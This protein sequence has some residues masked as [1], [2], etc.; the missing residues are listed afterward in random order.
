M[1][2]MDAETATLRGKM[3]RQRVSERWLDAIVVVAFHVEHGQVIE[4]VYAVEDSKL[5]ERAKRKICS[6]SLPDSNSGQNGDVQYFFRYRE[7][8][9]P[10]RAKNSLEEDFVYCSAFFRQIKDKTLKR[11]YFQKSVVLVS[12]NPFTSF[13]ED[14]TFVVG[15][16]FF[17]FG[18][19]VLE[20]ILR[21]VL[22][23]PRP[24]PGRT[25]KLPIAGSSI[26]TVVPRQFPN[27]R[28]LPA[29]TV[30]SSSAVPPSIEV[31]LET[32]VSRSSLRM[33]SA[34][35]EARCA[36][37][38]SAPGR[39]TSGP[40]AGDDIPSGSALGRGRA[41]D[42]A[43][44]G[45]GY[46]DAARSH[47]FATGADAGAGTGASASANANANA[48]VSARG[49]GSAPPPFPYNGASTSTAGVATAGPSGAGVNYSVARIFRHPPETNPG[50]FQDIPLF[51]TFGGLSVALWHI[52]ELALAGEPILV[53]APTPDRCSQAVLAIASLIAPI[54]YNGDYRPYFTI[55]DSDFMQI[56]RKHDETRGQDMPPTVL[57]VTNP[58]FLKTLEYWP[59]VISMGGS[60]HSAPEL[61]RSATPPPKSS[62]KGEPSKQ[63]EDIDLESG[64]KSR[65]TLGSEQVRSDPS[66]L[67][68]DARYQ[69]IIE[70][71]QKLHRQHSS[72]MSQASHQ[73]QQSL[74]VEG[75]DLKTARY[76]PTVAKRGASLR[77]LLTDQKYER[78]IILTR[79]DPGVPPDKTIL[80]Q[81]LTEHDAENADL[82]VLQG[83]KY[84]VEPPALSV[85]NALLRQ[86]FTHLTRCFL[87]PL[88]TYFNLESVGTRA[89]RERGIS[90]SAYNEPSLL[91]EKF[92][93][94]SFL[95]ELEAQLPE[96]ELRRTN[97]RALYRK[98][99]N[100]PNFLPWYNQQRAKLEFQL[101]HIYRHLRLNTDPDV[102]LQ[103]A[104]AAEEVR[105]RL[106]RR[107]LRQNAERKHEASGSLSNSEIAGGH[108]HGSRDEFGNEI[109]DVD[110]DDD[111]DDD[112]ADDER[113]GWVS[114]EDSSLVLM[115]RGA[116]SAPISS[117][118]ASRA[119]RLGKHTD[120]SRS[121]RLY[122]RVKRALD[123]ELAKPDAERDEELCSKI[124][125]HLE[126]VRSLIAGA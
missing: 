60:G 116:A 43:M 75:A 41:H 66:C 52:W 122:R 50:L 51:S 79:D 123:R 67:D 77:A 15:P 90:L 17:E 69:Q 59:N 36:S 5:S 25:F 124:Q 57:G 34:A 4:D 115:E 113:A 114:D 42:P 119:G 37:P 84:D 96:K 33:T 32:N 54:A 74:S 31:P 10:L 112:D 111:D 64:V 73:Q 95:L 110:V 23:W 83:D 44:L 91:I 46:W 86:H 125:E 39:V 118:T 16:L 7:S 117:P 63:T 109:E 65:A 8:D 49:N 40:S 35:T 47:G 2:K 85:N 102:L 58:Y 30:S 1:A 92:N 55:Y 108:G 20:A 53:L 56:S 48:S 11:G 106:L 45:P 19:V 6:L 101:E 13:L 107:Q 78:S 121:F 88:E 12:R 68:L 105:E 29:R 120:N 27:V 80:E 99:I 14:C 3:A 81:L 70:S 9:Q 93:E 62:P 98:F 22:S 100:G 61:S 76:H 72:C 97:W 38:A 103:T 21:D 82:V 18:K 71:S 126:I 26:T 89:A 94:E 28:S 87:R 24:E 104:G